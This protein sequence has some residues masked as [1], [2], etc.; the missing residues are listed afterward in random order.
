MGARRRL[1]IRQVLGTTI[2]ARGITNRS[3]LR[4]FK[5]WKMITNRGRDFKS[6]QKRLQT[7][8]GILNRDRDYK[9][10]QNMVSQMIESIQLDI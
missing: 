3:R 4:D 6:G 1:Q 10:V 2:G 5:S 8:A 9:S 7:R